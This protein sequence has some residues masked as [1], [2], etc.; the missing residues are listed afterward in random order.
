MIKYICIPINNKETFQDLKKEIIVANKCPSFYYKM[1]DI[2][3]PVPL[4]EGKCP[5]DKNS[6]EKTH[7]NGMPICALNINSAVDWKN[8]NGKIITVCSDLPPMSN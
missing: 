2:C 4:K 5:F 6:N 1:N 3:C 8:N 7:V